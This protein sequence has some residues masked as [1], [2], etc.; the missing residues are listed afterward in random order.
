MLLCTVL[1]YDY[2]Q[3]HVKLRNQRLID[4]ASVIPP[5]FRGL[6]KELLWK[7]ITQRA[8]ANK[9]RGFKICQ[10]VT[11]Y[12][13]AREQ[14][15]TNEEQ[16]AVET[17]FNSMFK[18]VVDHQTAEKPLSELWT[19]S[20]PRFSAE[21]ILETQSINGSWQPSLEWNNNVK[22]AARSGGYKFGMAVWAAIWSS[23]GELPADTRPL[24][25]LEDLYRSR[26]VNPIA[27]RD[28]MLNL[29]KYALELTS[30]L[31]LRVVQRD[32]LRE[33]LSNGDCEIVSSNY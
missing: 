26:I 31:R 21:C 18:E 1:I 3:M 15:L 30:P 29:K 9:D 20:I 10:N 17:G 4:Y 13:Q 23:E 6:V 14:W 19:V 22:E 32:G 2:T 24:H 5:R 16:A 25:Y 11:N 28:S 27:V 12:I 8:A 7:L 33:N